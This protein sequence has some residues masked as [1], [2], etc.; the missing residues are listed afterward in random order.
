MDRGGNFQRE[1]TPTAVARAYQERP[2][3]RVY[4]SAD[5]RSDGWYGLVALH[6]ARALRHRVIC[7]MYESNTGDSTLGRH[8]DAWDGVV[9]Q[10]RGTKHWTLWPDEPRD[11]LELVTETGDLLL[12]PHGMEHD[13]S[14]PGTPGY[15]VHAVFAAT[16]HHLGEGRL[17]RAG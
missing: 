13:V 8:H 9:V 12:L 5:A 7:T 1:V 2:R 10:L 6:L 3:T 17:T 11:P 4:E 15:S 14:T 16:S